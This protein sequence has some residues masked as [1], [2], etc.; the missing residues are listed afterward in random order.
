[1]TTTR[2]RERRRRPTSRGAD[3]DRAR[4]NRRGRRNAAARARTGTGLT[5]RKAL[6]RRWVAI[7]TVITVVALAYVMLFTS[8]LGVRSVDVLGARN[9]PEAQ[10]RDVAEVP[11]RRAMLRVDTGAIAERV[12]TLPG[13][14]TVDVSRSWPSTI[15]IAVTERE[16]IGFYNTGSALYFVDEGGVAYKEIPDQPEGFPELKLAEVAPGDPATRAVTTVLTRLPPQLRENVTV[17]GATTPGDIE[18]TLADGK[19]VRWGDADQNDRKAKVLAALLT[20]DG[21]TYDVSSPELPTIS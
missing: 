13:I 14:A 8:L 2:E 17:I 7:L 19:V 9:V 5:R 16:P 20:Q 18:F 3:E 10:I 12:A 15:E 21:K 6:R 11:D 1:M 4:P